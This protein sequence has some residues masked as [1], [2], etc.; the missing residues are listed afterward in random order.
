M[1]VIDKVINN[2]NGEEESAVI[3]ECIRVVGWQ[4]N[5]LRGFF[6]LEIKMLTELTFLNVDSWEMCDCLLAQIVVL[7]RQDNREVALS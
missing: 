2:N 4:G 6:F 5:P 7:R 3:E 1:F